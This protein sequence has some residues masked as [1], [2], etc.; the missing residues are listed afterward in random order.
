MD[1]NPASGV[2]I[3]AGGTGWNVISDHNMKENLRAC[4]K[5]VGLVRLGEP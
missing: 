2:S 1:G 5:K 3:P 4:L